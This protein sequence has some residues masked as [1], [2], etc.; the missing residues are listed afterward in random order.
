MEVHAGS[1]LA[2][3]LLEPRS[4]KSRPGHQLS[5]VALYPGIGFVNSNTAT[6]LRVCLYDYGR[7]SRATCKERDPE[8]GLD[9]L[10]AR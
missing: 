2:A 10:G 1:L 4:E 8:S 7:R 9:C 5:T 3:G 6:G